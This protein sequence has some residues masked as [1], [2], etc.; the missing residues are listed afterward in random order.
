MM[1]PIDN[2]ENKIATKKQ[3]LT[4]SALLPKNNKERKKEG[5]R[6]RRTMTVSEEDIKVK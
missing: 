6:E 4:K 1:Y 2:T 5:E 3:A